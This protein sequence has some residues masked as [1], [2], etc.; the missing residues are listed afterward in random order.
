MAHE[1]RPRSP[2]LTADQ[3]IWDLGYSRGYDDAL[4]DGRWQGEEAFQAW[5]L[6]ELRDL[7]DD[8][9]LNLRSDA[10]TPL[11][12]LTVIMALV[13]EGQ[14]IGVHDDDDDGKQEGA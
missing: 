7:A 8:V 6:A 3:R 14:P 11:E 9:R 5:L 12:I 10:T 4:E 2:R 1:T 13:E